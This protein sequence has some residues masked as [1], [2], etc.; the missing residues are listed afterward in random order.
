MKNFTIELKDCSDFEATWILGALANSAH[1]GVQSNALQSADLSAKAQEIFEGNDPDG[2]ISQTK[3]NRIA[4]RIV[5]NDEQEAW[6]QAQKDAAVA[7]WEVITGK[8]WAPFSGTKLPAMS[9]TAT[10]KFFADRLAKKSA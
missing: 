3:L 5:L 9:A 7:R 1:K 2:E 8:A 4:S 6:F 10:N